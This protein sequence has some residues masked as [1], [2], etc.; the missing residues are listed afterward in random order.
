MKAFK[1]YEDAKVYGNT[2]K[3]PAGGYVLKIMDA[4]VEEGKDGKDDSLLISFDIA[5]GEHAGFFSD[6]YK[7][8][9]QEDKKWKGTVYI[10]IPNDNNDP[11]E[12]WV[13]DR[14]RTFTYAVEDSNEGYHW[15][16]NEDGLKG[17]IFGG[18]FN[19]REYS[20][21]NRNGF[22]TR[23]QQRNIIPA[24]KIRKGDFTIPDRE[25]L[26]GSTQKKADDFV[27]VPDGAEEDLPF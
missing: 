10:R 18:V 16:W 26:D 22:Y 13:R 1:G 25:L 12:Q 3:L 11:K 20:F 14:F 2:P 6:N 24:E 5:E 9:T 4:K 27:T 19:E 17:K 21:N 23:L 15:D 7:N 8:Q